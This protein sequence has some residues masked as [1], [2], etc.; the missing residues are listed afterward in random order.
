MGIFKDN[1]D[2]DSS[3]IV[4]GVHILLGFVIISDINTEADL[5]ALTNNL[6]I[7]YGMICSY[8]FKNGKGK[9]KEGD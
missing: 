8:F 5:S 7:I 1:K 3:L 4:L 6:I 2:F 9:D